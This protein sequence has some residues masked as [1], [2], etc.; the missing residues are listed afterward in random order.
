MAH[1]LLARFF[2]GVIVGLVMVGMA[3]V[4]YYLLHDPD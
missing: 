3:H 4:V 1:D 2:V